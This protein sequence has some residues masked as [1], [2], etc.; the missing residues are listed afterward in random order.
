MNNFEH[1]IKDSICHENSNE[2][3]MIDLMFTSSHCSFQNSQAVG[4]SLSNF[5]KMTASVLVTYFKQKLLTTVAHWSYANYFND[6]RRQLTFEE[7]A[8]IQ[9]CNKTP[10]LSNYFNV[11][12]K[13]AKCASKKLQHVKENNSIFY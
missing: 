1:L 8:K 3:L 5:H 7:F 6:S 2:S 9:V 12:I 11:C 4:T 10:T 13:T